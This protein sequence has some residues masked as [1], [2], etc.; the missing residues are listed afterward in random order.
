MPW[1]TGLLT[2]FF[3]DRP[4]RDYDGARA[5]DHDAHAAFCRALLD[6]GVY[7]PPSQYEAW[8]PSLAHREAEIDA[9]LAAAREAFAA[10]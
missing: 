3:T 2:V 8:F 5:C 10:L 4:V 1:V 7:P 6:R 9:T